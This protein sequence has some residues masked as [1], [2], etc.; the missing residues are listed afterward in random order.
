MLIRFVD[1]LR[2]G[3][4][5]MK[6]RD[7]IFDFSEFFASCPTMLPDLPL[8][9]QHLTRYMDSFGFVT[10]TYKKFWR[11]LVFNSEREIGSSS[12]FTAMLSSL[13]SDP[14]THNDQR[15]DMVWDDLGAKHASDHSGCLLVMCSEEYLMIKANNVEFHVGKYIPFYAI[16][17]ATGYKTTVNTWLKNAKSMFTKDGFP[18]KIFKII[19]KV[20]MDDFVKFATT[21]ND[22]TVY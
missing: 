3:G 21:M 13:R 12:T 11:S 17:F 14:S 5:S 18:K 1:R 4:T 20:Q 2:R 8:I 9:S 7:F 16:V 10:Y 15:T 19:G 22:S 6:Y